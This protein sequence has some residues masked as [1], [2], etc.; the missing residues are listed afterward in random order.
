MSRFRPMTELL[1]AQSTTDV[2]A[3]N[4]PATPKNHDN[5]LINKDVTTVTHV[6]AQKTEKCNENSAGE[7]VAKTVISRAK[8]DLIPD[9]D[10]MIQCQACGHWWHR[11]RH[12]TKYGGLWPELDSQRWR[13]CMNF[14]SR[15]YA[16]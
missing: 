5:L 14:R 12:P 13:R 7:E 1:A 15:G 2:T 4:Q 9:E 6:T 16:E 8:T 3:C 11:C 10:G